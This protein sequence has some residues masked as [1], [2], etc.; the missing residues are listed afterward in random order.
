M[1][2]L[3]M[4]PAAL[5]L[6]C[7]AAGA[8]AL[9][10]ESPDLLCRCPTHPVGRRQ[11]TDGKVGCGSPETGKLPAFVPSWAP[12]ARACSG[13]ACHLSSSSSVARGCLGPADQSCFGCGQLEVHECRL[14]I[15]PPGPCCKDPRST[16]RSAPIRAGRLSSSHSVQ[17]CH[18]KA[19][20]P[21]CCAALTKVPIDMQVAITGYTVGGKMMAA[22]SAPCL[23]IQFG[24]PCL[25]KIQAAE[26]SVQF[27]YI[28]NATSVVGGPPVS[29][30][31]YLCY[32]T[33]SQIGRPWRAT[34]AAKDTLVRSPALL[35]ASCG[36]CAAGTTTASLLMPTSVPSTI[37]LGT[38]LRQ[39]KRWTLPA[40]DPGQDE[41]WLVLATP[42][43]LHDLMHAAPHP[44]A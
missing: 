13:V 3:S 24:T 38:G 33:W 34:S 32:S 26:D 37:L 44:P 8:F 43:L 1:A 7:C 42:E 36:C 31:A 15:G 25:Q 2:R 4:V 10:R 20:T 19:P 17:L 14:A 27:S 28:L 11:L 29:A 22:N 40:T 16:V 41:F 35:A 5:L 18:S 9:T 30:N 39:L 21:A 12:I 23:G 6:A